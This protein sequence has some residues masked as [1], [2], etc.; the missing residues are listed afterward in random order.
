MQPNQAPRLTW[1]HD[2]VRDRRAGATSLAVFHSLWGGSNSGWVEGH[3]VSGGGPVAMTVASLLGAAEARS[4][5]YFNLVLS[6]KRPQLLH[7][8]PTILQVVT[9]HRFATGSPIT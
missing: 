1:Q 8:S 2:G 4:Q 5:N 6:L 7:I 9:G 3:A